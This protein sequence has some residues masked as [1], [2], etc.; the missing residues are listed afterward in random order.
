[1]ETMLLPGCFHEKMA[2]MLF[3]CNVVLTSSEF[4]TTMSYSACGKMFWYGCGST[5]ATVRGCFP[6]RKTEYLLNEKLISI[7]TS[8]TLNK[9]EFPYLKN[10]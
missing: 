7:Q 10:H 6:S 8:K 1:M 9:V 4:C 3:I 2:V 5:F